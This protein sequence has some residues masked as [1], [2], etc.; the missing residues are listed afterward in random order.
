MSK[1]SF[2]IALT[3]V[4]GSVLIALAIVGVVVKRALDY[5]EQAHAGSGADV[6]IEIKTGMTFPQIARMLADKHVVDRPT[7][8]RM[9]W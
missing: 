1:R 4:V 5:P 9:E 2:R 6:E 7:W 3:V 8:F